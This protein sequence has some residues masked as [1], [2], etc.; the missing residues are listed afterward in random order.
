MKRLRFGSAV[1]GLLILCVAILPGCGTAVPDVKGMTATQAEKAITSAGFQLGKVTYD[2]KA[3]G[4]VGAVV[5]QDPT[6]GDRAKPGSLIVITI[7]GPPPVVVPSLV[8]LGK[9]K[10]ATVLT[11]VGLNLGHV[12]DSYDASASANTI[13]SQTPA[14]K[15]DAPG[16]SNISIIVSKGPKPVAVPLVKDKTQADGTKL[17]TSAGLKVKVDQRASTAA[18]DTIIDQNP[19]SGEAQPGSTVTITVSTGVEMVKV[20]NISGMLDPDPVLKRAGLKPKGIPIHGPIE[21]DAAGYMEAYRQR[22]R[23]GAL[24]TKGTTVTYH[25]WWESQ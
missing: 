21:S 11:A 5:G 22:P 2:G 17:L 4:A 10:A 16:G 7:T 12:A 8:G 19:A 24:V 14:A 20:P 3:V 6:A 1:V 18:K 13:I 15:S 25:F 23:A 9:D